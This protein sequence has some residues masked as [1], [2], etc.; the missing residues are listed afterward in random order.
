MPKK[1]ELMTPF[2][3][4]QYMV[5]KDFEVYYYND[6]K[7]T[8]VAEHCHDYYEFY[9][10]VEGEAKIQVDQITY[11]IKPGDFL[12]IPPGIMHCPVA[13][14]QT[15]PYRRFILW[16]SQNYCNQLVQ[17]STDYGYLMQYV[18]TKHEYLF[19][20]DIITFHSIES[21]IFSMLGEIKNQRFGRDAFLSL[22]INELILYL[23]RTIYERN[24]MK[25]IDSDRDMS[26][27]VQ[28]FIDAHLNEEL[29][30]ERLEQEFFVSKFHISHIF[31]DTFGIS[32]HNYITQ[33]RLYA[34]RDAIK[35]QE[36]IVET[37]ERFGFNDYS[38]F[39]RAFKKAF[40][41][42]P[43]EYQSLYRI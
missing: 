32:I 26:V 12:L 27:S 2:S 41:M 18:K 8:K 23:N 1:Q 37:Y 16:I 20:N 17:A 34:C 21:R 10:F 3:T 25:Q 6:S 15:V 28:Q 24:S 36:P 11:H 40:G 19:S 39:Y 43:K 13:I 35:C 38:N 14:S 31:K 33:K 5:S 30:L 4:R 42:S 29:S 7:P 22:Q 9:F